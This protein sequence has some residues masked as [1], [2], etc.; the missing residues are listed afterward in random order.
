MQKGRYFLLITMAQQSPD[1]C[2][3]ISTQLGSPTSRRWVPG[4]LPPIQQL[5][6]AT[7]RPQARVAKEAR[8]W[9]RDR[10]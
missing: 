3:M 8:V 1:P 4:W 7:P 6:R 9:R 5:P 2:A 10:V